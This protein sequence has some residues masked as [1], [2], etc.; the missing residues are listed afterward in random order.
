MEPRR[1]A[2]WPGLLE[3][4]LPVKF[5]RGKT[6]RHQVSDEIIASRGSE[7][8]DMKIREQ[9]R[10]AYNLQIANEISMGPD[11]GSSDTSSIVFDEIFTLLSSVS[12]HY[13]E[14]G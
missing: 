9:Y 4:P 7:H 5:C 3:L 12:P 1:S 2:P 6:A 8:D 13:R 11:C 14:V 10:R